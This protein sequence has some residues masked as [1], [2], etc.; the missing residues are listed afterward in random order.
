MTTAT[1]YVEV[2]R[3]HSVGSGNGFGGPDTY[4][5]VQV[6]PEGV[7]RL[8]VLNHDHA[9]RRGI[10]LIHCGQGYSRNQGPRSSYG[11]ARAEAN[12]IA[13]EINSRTT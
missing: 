12:R 4:F 1:A 10:E 6:V 9:R 2:R 3:Q 7:E 5:C 13:D 8:K 11:K